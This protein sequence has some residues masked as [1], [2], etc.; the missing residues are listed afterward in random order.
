M[1]PIN[2][3]HLP[4]SLDNSAADNANN[5]PPTF[6]KAVSPTTNLN[7]SSVTFRSHTGGHQAH[8]MSP[9]T[10]PPEIMSK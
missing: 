9:V 8:P 5:D 1:D 2:D 3:S 4:A 7:G 10:N 6:Q